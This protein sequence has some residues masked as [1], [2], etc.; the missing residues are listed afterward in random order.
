[1]LTIEPRPIV[2][3]LTEVAWLFSKAGRQMIETA[4]EPPAEALR[5]FW[6]STRQLQR[7]WEWILDEGSLAVLDSRQ[8]EEA[9][10]HL[11]KTELLT[12][13]WATILGSI[14]RRTGKS[15]QTG[16]A[17]NVLGG[18]LQIRHRLQSQLVTDLTLPP[19]WAAKLDRLCRRYDRWTDLLI[20]TICG[21]DEYFQFAINSERAR[22]FAEEARGG[23]D[24]RS[25]ELLMGAGVRQSFFSHVPEVSLDE[26]SS[27]YGIA[28]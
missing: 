25:V 5:E 4:S 21:T 7:S 9:L 1:M 23:E 19:R 13:I 27:L 3:S 24:L 28:G 17:E 6:H 26:I 8:F 16:S 18:L 12:R 22:D 2:N 11:L 15:D 14:D 10:A 20:G